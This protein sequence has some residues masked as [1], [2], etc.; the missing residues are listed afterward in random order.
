MLQKAQEID[1]KL[2]N[3][4]AIGRHSRHTETRSRSDTKF[5]PNFNKDLNL[6]NFNT[7]QTH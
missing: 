2:G 6:T 7:L 1:E 3:Q 5:I 4:A